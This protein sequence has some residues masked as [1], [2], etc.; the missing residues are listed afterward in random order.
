VPRISAQA[1]T[2]PRAKAASILAADGFTKGPDGVLTKGGVPFTLQ[3]WNDVSS[4]TNTQINIILK[5]EWAK[6]GVK[7]DLHAEDSTTMY[8]ANGPQ[9]TKQ[10]TGVAYAWYNSSDPTDTYYWASDQIPTS[11]TGSGGNDVA[12][13]Y[14]FSFQ[15]QI[16]K[17]T[18]EADATIDLAKRKALFFQ[19]QE[20][21]ANEVPVIFI[22][23]EPLLYV[24]PAGLKGFA[25]NPW[26]SLLTHV[27]DWHY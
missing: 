26:I 10:M 16:D 5:A 7:V 14:K 3:L 18:H 8:G 12:Y 22:D 4:S 6:I 9:F 13:F 2:K 19:I 27:A 1:H 25:P 24:V 17:L 15:S 23:W 20:L 11:P 21:I